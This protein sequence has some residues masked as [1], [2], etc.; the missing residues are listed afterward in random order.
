MMAKQHGPSP[1][2]AREANSPAEVMCRP[3]HAVNVSRAAA[4]VKA[5]IDS[6]IAPQRIKSR[7]GPVPGERIRRTMMEAAMDQR[8]VQSPT[9]ARQGSKNG[10][11]RYVL[12]ISTALVV[13]AFAAAYITSV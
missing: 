2:G 9:E 4:R 7:R 3:G 11:V 10:I 5:R 8:I 6:D 1:S 12:A 13:I